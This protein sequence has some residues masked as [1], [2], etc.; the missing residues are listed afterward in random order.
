MRTEEA[1][2][3]RAARLEQ[4]RIVIIE[5]WRRNG[6]TNKYV[7]D[8]TRRGTSIISKVK[9]G[10]ANISADL[11]HE[12]IDLFELD[13]IRLFMAIEMVGNG[14]LYFDPTFRNV[15]HAS[16]CFVREMLRVMDE[17]I[18]PEQKAFFAA[19]PDTAIGALAGRAGL[20]VAKRFAAIMP[21]L[22]HLIDQSQT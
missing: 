1:E 12:L 10:R 6:M 13:R 14:M 18:S 15:C 16:M 9:N 3:R 19:F 7:A 2:S 4:Y 20:D 21:P 8:C 11:R 5:A 17:D 22:G